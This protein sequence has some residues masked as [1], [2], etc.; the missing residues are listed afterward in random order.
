MRPE[1]AS[2]MAQNESVGGLDASGRE[3]VVVTCEELD[4]N[5]SLVVTVADSTTINNYQPS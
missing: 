2:H 4:H 5:I 1:F 3:S